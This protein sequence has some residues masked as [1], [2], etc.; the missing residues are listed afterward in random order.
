M[1]IAELARPEIR[2]LRPYEAAIQVT[3]TI[4]L[5]ANEAPWTSG[6]DPFRRPLNRYPEIRPARLRTALAGRFGTT[7]ERLLVTRGTSEAIDLLIRAFCREGRDNIVTTSPTFSMY[8]HYA[9]IQGAEVRTVETRPEADFAPTCDELLAACDENSRLVFLCT[10]NN[11]T[12]TSLSRDLLTSFLD[13][14]G[15]RSAVVIDEAYIE[16]S[17]ERSMAEL[18]DAYPNLVVLRTLSKALAF[19]GAR[20]GAVMGP[21]AV[22]DML[23]AIQA[24]YAL[25]TPV[26]ECVEDAL[27][28]RWIGEADRKVSQIISEREKLRAGLEASDL[29][30]KVWPSSANFLLVETTNV[31]AIMNATREAGILLRYFG[32]SLADCIRISVGTPEEN[33]ALIGT[34]STLNAQAHD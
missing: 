13:A 19:A 11:P 30:R 33:A 18:L 25:S 14:R 32:G 2:R 20:C 12:G 3:D 4:R 34:L 27:S 9:E 28:D 29:I 17:G 21:E 15:N 31:D 7:P 5:N 10:P 6:A 23:N 1:S 22:I 26:V 8:G 16:F 24:P